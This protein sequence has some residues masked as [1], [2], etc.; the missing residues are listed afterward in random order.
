MKIQLI[1]QTSTGSSYPFKPSNAGRQ[2]AHVS[3][4]T[5]KFSS[6][7]VRN[8]QLYMLKDGFEQFFRRSQ[9]IKPSE[10]KEH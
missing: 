2:F 3:M 10:Q 7:K 6:S 4:V 1:L 5:H 9:N 8:S